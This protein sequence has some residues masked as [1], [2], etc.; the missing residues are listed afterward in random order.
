[1]LE[2]KREYNEIVQYLF[3]DFKERTIVQYSHR[4]WVTHETFMLI[5]MSSNGT[6]SKVGVHKY[7]SD[8]F[9]IKNGPKHDTLT[10]LLFNFALE[11]AIKK[12]QENQV[13]LKLN[14]TH[15]LLTYANNINLL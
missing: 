14:E 3:L 13:G 5:R 1:M 7:L 15:Q 6:Y 8:N 9:P 10:P 12:V 11:Y 2:K 4:V